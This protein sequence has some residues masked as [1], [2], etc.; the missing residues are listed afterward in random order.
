MTIALRARRNKV[1]PGIE[2]LIGE[3]GIAQTALAPPA[4][5]SSM[6]KSGM[7]WPRLQCRRENMC[8]FAESMDFGWKWNRRGRGIGTRTEPIP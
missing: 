4:K 1:T 7:R 5:C 3:I 8:E 6:V 2:G